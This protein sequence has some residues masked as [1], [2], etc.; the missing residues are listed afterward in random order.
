MIVDLGNH[1]TLNLAVR[2]I[3]AYCEAANEPLTA[4]KSPD[5]AQLNWHAVH[6]RWRSL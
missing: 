5:Y 4:D 3:A 2:Q 1:A 6:A